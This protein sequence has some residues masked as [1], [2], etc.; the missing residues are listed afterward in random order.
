M[1]GQIYRPVGHLAERAKLRR[2]KYI[3]IS[4]TFA[5]QAKQQHLALC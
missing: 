2:V 5:E 4:T 1:E 3:A